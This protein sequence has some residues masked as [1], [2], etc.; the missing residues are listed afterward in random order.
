MG[1]KA[2]KTVK[3][4]LFFARLYPVIPYTQRQKFQTDSR[5]RDKIQRHGRTIANII[6]EH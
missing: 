3:I 1:L 4:A 2:Q 6:Q 5:I